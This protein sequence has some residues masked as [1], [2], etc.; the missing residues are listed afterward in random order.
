MKSILGI[1]NAL[2]DIIVKLQ[3]DALLKQF[4]L[5]LGSMT[6][7]WKAGKTYKT[8]VH[9]RPDGKGSTDFTGYFCDETG[10]WHL[11]ASFKRPQTN[12]CLVR[13]RAP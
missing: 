10:T 5:P 6:Y 1:G 4:H 8:L 12:T 13:A 11:L 9:V 3:N 7:P 2:T